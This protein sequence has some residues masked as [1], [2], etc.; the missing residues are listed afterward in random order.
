MKLCVFHVGTKNVSY[1]ICLGVFPVLPV[2]TVVAVV[3][4]KALAAVMWLSYVT[5]TKGMGQL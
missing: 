5:V 2:S 4:G 3:T 1:I